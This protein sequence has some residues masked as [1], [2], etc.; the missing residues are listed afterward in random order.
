MPY[1]KV[2][3]S[4]YKL[5]LLTASRIGPLVQMS[6][7][8]L[9]PSATGSSWSMRGSVLARLQAHKS[10]KIYPKDGQGLLRNCYTAHF[11]DKFERRKHCNWRSELFDHVIRFTTFVSFTG[12]KS[13]WKLSGGPLISRRYFLVRQVNRKHLSAAKMYLTAKF[14]RFWLLAISARLNA[15]HDDVAPLF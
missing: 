2:F 9:L 15:L 8:A 14:R 7:C 3:E 1:T 13:W 5:L 10:G 11:S 12:G 6:S 4:G